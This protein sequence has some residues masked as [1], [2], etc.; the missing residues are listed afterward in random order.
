[1]GVL[2]IRKKPGE[3]LTLAQRDLIEVF[4]RQ[5]ALSVERETLRAAGEREKLLAESEKLHQALLDSV[6]HELR[7]PLAVIAAV[8]ENIGRAGRRAPRAAWWRRAGRPSPGST[9]W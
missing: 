2:G 7:T 8:F 9:G 6:S 3:V 4:A 5:L 1:M